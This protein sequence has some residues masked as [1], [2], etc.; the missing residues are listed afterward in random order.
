MSLRRG[1]KQRIS[2]RGSFSR[3]AT[4]DE[5]DLHLFTTIGFSDNGNGYLRGGDPRTGKNVYLHRLIAGAK[6]GQ[7]VDHINRDTYDN[8]R[9]NLRFVTRSENALNNK[10]RAAAHA[11][12]LEA[13]SNVRR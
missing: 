4:V 13:A 3:P 5:C 9:C 7:I 10:R 12:I 8:R 6:P 11:T 2:S 1:E